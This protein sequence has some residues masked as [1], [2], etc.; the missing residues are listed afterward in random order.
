MNELLSKLKNSINKKIYSQVKPELMN[1]LLFVPINVRDNYLF[2]AINSKTDKEKVSSILSDIYN[3]TIKYIQLADNDLNELLTAPASETA[4]TDSSKTE[5]VVAKQSRH[6]IGEMLL[7]DG[8]ITENQLLEA[9]AESKKT[10]MPIGS[11]LVKLNYITLEQLKRYLKLQTGFDFVSS[12]QI[13]KQAPFVNLLSEDF[14]KV[15]KCIPVFSDGKTL[16]IGTVSILKPAIVKNISYLTGLQVKQLL[17]TAFEFENALEKYFSEEKKL[18]EK[19]MQAATEEAGSFRQEQSLQD[20]VEKD[21]NDSA[22][23]VAAFVNKIVTSAIDMG[24]SDIHIEPRMDSYIV[25]YRKDGM[26]QKVFDI[27]NKVEN[28]ILSR[29]KV[30][31]RLNIAE[32]RRPQDGTFS[33]SYKGG[34]YDFRIS[35]LPVSGKEK[36]VIRVLAP[37]VSLD[38]QDKKINLVGAQP[39]EIE[40]IQ[41]M[42]SAPNGIILTSGPTGSGKTTTLYSVL[43]SL[44]DVS[45]NITTIEDPIEIRLDGIN[46]SQINV[47]AGI[48]FASCMKSILRQD[49]DI[50]LIGEIRDYE[51]L[52]I[53]ISAALTGHLVLS[54]VHTNSAAA[55]VTRLIEMGAKDY[56]VASTLTGVIAQRLV[57]KLCDKCKE[58]YLPTLEEA[59]KVLKDPKEIEEFMKTPIYRNVGCENCDFTGFVGRLGVYE[60]MPITKSI[61][62]LIAQGA[63]DLQIEEQAVK[64]GMSSLQQACLRHIRNGQTTISEFVRVLGLVT[65]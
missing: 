46:Q 45:V 15:N 55:T 23:S 42:C 37:A 30:I 61:K 21:L 7:D 1:E 47:K 33:M 2:V 4:E 41:K 27:P 38:A 26:L 58:Q 57:R 39:N 24:V 62:T 20:M 12:E 48:T 63:H 10:K 3:Y 17:I 9:M 31:S 44:N 43:K 18:T 5:S 8:I 50:I 19:L 34:S 25:R 14:I 40:K 64:E 56:L 36:V 6:K 13:G 49:P 52:E 54:T 59:Q 51:T 16:T 11:C 29:F 60:I 32:H 65:D 35:T 22:G 53:A 28:S